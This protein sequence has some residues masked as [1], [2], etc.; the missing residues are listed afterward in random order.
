MT[1]LQA[2]Q[3]VDIRQFIKKK[4]NDSNININKRNFGNVSKNNANILNE[5]REVVDDNPSFF[6]STATTMLDH[7][8]KSNKGDKNSSTTS[9]T[10]DDPSD[11]YYN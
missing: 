9:E 11:G 1:R 4:S 5:N 10:S 8:N 6:R 7:D 2:E 3:T